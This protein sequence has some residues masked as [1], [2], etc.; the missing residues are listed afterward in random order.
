MNC[1]RLRVTVNRQLK[2]CQDGERF[3]EFVGAARKV[4]SA[5]AAWRNR[6]RDAANP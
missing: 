2:E 6:G 5:P 4:L 3:E 1:L